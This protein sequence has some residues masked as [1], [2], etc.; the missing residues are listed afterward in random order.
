MTQSVP[1]LEIDNDIVIT[2]L[3]DENKR[4]KEH[5]TQLVSKYEEGEVTQQIFPSKAIEDCYKL[6]SI[7]LSALRE[8]M[9]IQN[10]NDELHKEMLQSRREISEKIQLQRTIEKFVNGNRLKT[11]INVRSLTVCNDNSLTWTTKTKNSKRN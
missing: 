11:S 7:L 5:Q 6:N 10:K 1:R 8:N 3:C 2:K 9:E 4:L